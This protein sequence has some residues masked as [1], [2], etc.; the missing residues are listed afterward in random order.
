MNS[1]VLP[2]DWLSANI[3]PIYKKNDRTISSMQTTGPSRLLQ[4]VVK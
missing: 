1:G 3:T 4:F 2:S